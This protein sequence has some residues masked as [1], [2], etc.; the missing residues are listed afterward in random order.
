MKLFR[1]CSTPDDATPLQNN[2][3]LP[4][5]RQIGGTH[6]TVVPATDDDRV[7]HQDSLERRRH[8]PKRDRAERGVAVAEFH[9]EACATLALDLYWLAEQRQQAG[10]QVL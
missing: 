7:V 5:H 3:F 8:L 4:G 1:D 10:P 9:R 6:Q 2:D